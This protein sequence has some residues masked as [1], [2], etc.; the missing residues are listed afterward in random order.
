MAIEITYP[1]VIEQ[2]APDEL[3]V[4]IERASYLDWQEE[5]ACKGGDN[6]VF[7]HPEGERGAAI[8]KRNEVARAICAVCPV[9]LECMAS[10]V[11]KR[12]RYGFWGASELERDQALA[13]AKRAGARAQASPQQVVY[14]G[15]SRLVQIAK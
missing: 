1:E 12:E 11:I 8:E 6:S 10:S 5:A 15:L 3:E 13:Y 2:R 9:R 4:A 7:F 14:M